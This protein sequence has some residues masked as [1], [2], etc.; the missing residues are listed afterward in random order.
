MPGNQHRMPRLARGVYVNRA[1]WVAG[2]MVLVAAFLVSLKAHG[3][4]PASRPA[5]TAPVVAQGDASA[6]E[7]LLLKLSDA[8][9][10]GRKDILEQLART[11]DRRLEAVFAD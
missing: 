6:I 4:E 1:R 7:A 5:S 2:L 11:G 8:D 3:D 9:A 10:G